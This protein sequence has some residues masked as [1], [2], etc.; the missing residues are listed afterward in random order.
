MNYLLANDEI[1]FHT[2]QAKSS[3]AYS[4][5]IRHLHLSTSTNDIQTSLINEGHDVIRVT[6]II[7]R[8]T[9]VNL[10]LF[11]ADII[12]ADNNSDILKLNSIL[13]TK[14]KVAIPRKKS[15]PSQCT[16]CQAYFHTTNYC[17]YHPRCVKCG[18]NHISSDC[19][20]SLSV[21]TKFALCSGPHTSSY[22]GYPRYKKIISK[23]GK[24]TSRNRPIKLNLRHNAMS[25]P[26]RNGILHTP[27]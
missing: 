4:V 24:P 8:F 13:H 1:M 5:Y 19:T 16:N 17:R 23:H 10:P 14:V 27:R 26:S 6:N 3:K 11:R 21:S 7:N 9:K 20:K 2:Y 12:I 22:K 15:A 25:T 18:Q